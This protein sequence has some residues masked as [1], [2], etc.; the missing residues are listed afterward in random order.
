MMVNNHL[1]GATVLA[2]DGPFGGIVVYG[3]DNKIVN[4]LVTGFEIG[5][6]LGSYDFSTVPT[7]NNKI[8]GNRLLAPTPIAI[9][10]DGGVI[11]GT[12]EHGNK[13][14]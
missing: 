1:V 11:S 14:Q 2:D 3:R 4:N 13:T 10:N 9:M 7:V 5:L 8:I 12:K 6:V